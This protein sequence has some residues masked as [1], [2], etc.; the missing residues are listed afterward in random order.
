M[1]VWGIFPTF[2]PEKSFNKYEKISPPPAMTFDHNAEFS[3]KPI[4]WPY[5]K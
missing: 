5:R 4:H 1:G 2:L 3:L